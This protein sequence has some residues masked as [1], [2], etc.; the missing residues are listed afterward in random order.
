MPDDRNP[1]SFDS[2]R[3]LAMTIGGQLNEHNLGRLASV[4]VVDEPTDAPGEITED[5]AR[6]LWAS[7]ALSYADEMVA[8]PVEDKRTG[9]SRLVEIEDTGGG[10][11]LVR[12]P[13]ESD[14]KKVRG[15][16]K[17]LE[18]RAELIDE[19]MA[20][21]DIG[22]PLT[23]P[24][25]TISEEG[26]NGWYHVMGPGLDEPEIVRGEQAAL[27]RRDEL[28]RAAANPPPGPGGTTQPP[29]QPVTRADRTAPGE[30]VGSGRTVNDEERESADEE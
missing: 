8:T 21:I 6:R 16:D 27:A 14:P 3:P 15:H 4:R 12:A 22:Q 25:F 23:A 30:I 29:P 5:V 11:F 19:G 10:W 28:E 24:M 26:S 9:V 20:K 2:T 18:R 17:A 13:W 7:G 1:E